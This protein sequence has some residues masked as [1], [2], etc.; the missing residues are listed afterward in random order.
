VRAG[1]ELLEIR[2]ADLRFTDVE[3]DVFLNRV[4]GLG[5]E[6]AQVAALMWV[7]AG[8]TQPPRARPEDAREPV[9]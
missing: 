6:P 9:A 1:G 8:A 5:L 7:S 4:M 3:A 2:A